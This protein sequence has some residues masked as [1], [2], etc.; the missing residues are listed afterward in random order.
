VTISSSTKSSLFIDD[1]SDEAGTRR[2][3]LARLA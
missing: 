3:R 1:L 2:G